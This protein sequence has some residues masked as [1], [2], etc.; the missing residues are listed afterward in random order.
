MFFVSEELTFQPSIIYQIH[1]D[2][3]LINRDLL[4]LN[5]TNLQDNN[6]ELKNEKTVLKSRYLSNFEIS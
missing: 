1:I 6:I 2:L 3:V 5:L 4:I